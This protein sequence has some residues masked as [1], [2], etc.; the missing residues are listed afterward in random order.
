[1]APWS[2]TIPPRETMMGTESDKK[3]TLNPEARSACA[4]CV[5]D[6]YLKDLIGQGKEGECSYGHKASGTIAL[7]DLAE[8]IRRVFL[9]RYIEI[10]R[11]PKHV[12]IPY[13]SKTKSS[14]VLNNEGSSVEEIIRRETGACK[15]LAAD[16]QRVMEKFVSGDNRKLHQKAESPFDEGARYNHK[17][18]SAVFSGG[19]WDELQRY[20]DRKDN[21]KA[22]RLLDSVFCGRSEIF[23]NA[24]V[25]VEKDP[26]TEPYYI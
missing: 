7:E 4:E 9:N 3:E 18:T 24:S 13:T 8:Y 2:G 1:M 21:E 12:P 11:S 26:E 14:V 19:L 16:L 10:T 22:E 17:G 23:D 20:I 15:E 25:I 5:N 6:R